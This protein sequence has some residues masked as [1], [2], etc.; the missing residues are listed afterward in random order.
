MD[1]FIKLFKTKIDIFLLYFF[2]SRRNRCQYKFFSGR[3]FCLYNYVQQAHGY[4]Q[5]NTGQC[6]DISGTGSGLETILLIVA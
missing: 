6:A 5:H 2:I 3:F 1:I 4:P